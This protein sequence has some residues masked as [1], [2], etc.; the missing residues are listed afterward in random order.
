MAF[1]KKGLDLVIVIIA[2]LM[3]GYHLLHTQHML[4][5]PIEHNNLHFAF[6][7]VLVFL[8]RIKK[9]TSTLQR[10]FLYF[11]VMLSLFATMYIFLNYTE[12]MEV[13]GPLYMLTPLDVA[14]SLMLI[15]LALEGARRSFGSVFPLV[16]LVFML[17]AYFGHHLKGPLA[18]GTIP[19]KEL[20]S[21]YVMGFSGGMYGTV[22]GIS[23]NYIFLFVL[24]G[25]ILNVTGAAR[26]FTQ[27]GSLAAK[28]IAGGPAIT[29]IVSSALM[30]SIN[31][32]AMANV[33]TTGAFTIP[34]MKKVGYKPHQA[35]AV[36]AAAS[37][38]G[39][40]MPP[41]M[42]AAAFMMAEMLE[43][44]YLKVM[45]AATIPAFLY[46]F[47]VGVYAQLQAKKMRID[48]S[49]V[50]PSAPTRELLADAPLFVV[51]LVIIIVLLILR[52]SPMFTIFWGIMVLLMLNFTQ[53]A[54]RKEKGA[55]ERLVKGFVSGAT[56]GAGIALACAVIGPIMATITK[57]VLGLKVAGIIELWSGG[58]LIYALIM[59]MVASIIL[60]MGVPTLP[61]YVLVALVAAPVL[62]KM[63]VTL[64]SAHMF[65]FIFAIFSC[66]TPPIA[67]S[68]IPAAGLA[69]SSYLR[70][71]FE[72]TKVGIIGFMVPYLVVFAPELMLEHASNVQIVLSTGASV[73]AILSF[74]RA[75][76]GYGS[77]DLRVYE[78]C[79]YGLVSGLLLAY[80][81]TKNIPFLLLGLILMIAF[82]LL[83]RVGAKAVPNQ[84]I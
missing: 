54:I 56:A 32:A 74:G 83:E 49:G 26:F 59:T 24:F 80:V 79:T 2:L 1:S 53:V 9:S 16:C 72:S 55:I 69:Q 71:A 38:G 70:T 15:F 58:I 6:A 77:R 7:L 45:I 40:I 51:P 20:M 73:M 11:F 82:I 21:T 63:N 39:Q 46:F 36:E 52:Y 81:V 78:R 41:V 66:L 29:A 12:L 28:R 75:I 61:A 84:A 13:R 76:V 19:I 34:L 37:T 25:G 23:A 62:V 67:V 44:P 17:Y 4:L 57:T 68:S 22:L 3:G 47:S 50:I 48:A 27:L 30:G 18:T 60:G 14:V 10:I 33:A 35:G 5:G 8:S 65:C 42:G 31:G 43:L 64:L